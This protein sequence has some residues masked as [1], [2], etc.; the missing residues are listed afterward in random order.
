MYNSNPCGYSFPYEISNQVGQNGTPPYNKIK[1]GG[2]KMIAGHLTTKNGYWYLILQ[3]RDEHGQPKSKWIA[4]HMKV[5]GNKRKAEAMLLEARRQ[6]TSLGDM[7]KRTRDTLLSDYLLAWVTTCKPKV[8][9]STYA[10]YKNCIDRLIAPYFEKQRIKLLD[11]KPS[12]LLDY[13]DTLYARGLSGNTV[14]H[15]HVLL[16]KA[17]E[18]AHLRELIPSNPADNI[19]RPRKGQFV[20]NCYIP[21]ECKQLLTAIKGD[22]LELPVLLSVLYGLRRSEVLGLKWGAIDL[23]RN[24]ITISHSVVTASVDGHCQ[25]ICQDKLKRKSSFRSLPLTPMIVDILRKTAETRYGTNPP[26]SGN[27]ICV[28]KNGKLLTPNYLSEHFPLLLAKNNLRRIRFHDLRHSC[29]NLLISAHVPLIEVQQWLG[30]STIST[31]ADLYSHLEFA[32]KERSVQTITTLL[33][34]GDASSA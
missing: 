23:T 4:T 12:D 32:A 9:V 21:D 28:N 18:E 30:H 26:P 2:T 5:N 24:T 27:Y 29:A 15:Y 11:L 19:P 22:P 31:T 16:R 7:R 14:L 17:L 3:I 10:G 8:A 34:Q 25:T 1:N 20:A 6:Y 33:F 13:Y